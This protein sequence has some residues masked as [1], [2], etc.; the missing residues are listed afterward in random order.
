MERS[1]EELVASYLN[2]EEQ[3]LRDLIARYL[4]VLY[5]F[6]YRY[7]GNSPDAEDI[8]QEVFV[9]VWKNLARYSPETSFRTWIFAI[10]KNAAIDWLRKK[11]AVPFSQFDTDEGENVLTET[12][13]DP[14]PLPGEIAEQKDAANSVAEAM[15]EL[16]PDAQ[17]VLLSRYSE[18]LTFREI[19]ETL[20]KP[21]NTVK[22]RYRRAVA[23]LK[24]ILSGS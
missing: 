2:G 6:A 20:G 13:P 4:R 16:P 22:S 1:D 23:Q 21:L 18:H 9:K 7:T 5:H 12:L 10:A 24:R 19:A 3:A 15:E 8:T 11:R 17:R 14:A